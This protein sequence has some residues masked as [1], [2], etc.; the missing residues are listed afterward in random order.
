MSGA[1]LGGGG[2]LPLADGRCPGVPGQGLA[3]F[4]AAAV[5]LDDEFGRHAAGGRLPRLPRSRRCVSSRP[6]RRPGTSAAVETVWILRGWASP[7]I[8]DPEAPGF[9]AFLPVRSARSCS[10][11][12]AGAGERAPS[13]RSPFVQAARGRWGAALV[14]G[15][16]VPELAAVAAGNA[17]RPRPP[18]CRCRG[19]DP[20]QAAVAA[21]L[22]VDRGW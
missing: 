5:V 15:A 1:A 19:G 2:N 20:D 21:H 14:V 4:V 16:A 3:E 10:R 8:L 12:Q 18:A 11:R 22:Q 17:L 6:S 9:D 13:S 7:Q